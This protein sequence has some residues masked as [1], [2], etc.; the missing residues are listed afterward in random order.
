MKTLRQE[1]VAK[2]LCEMEEHKIEDT[3][4]NRISLLVGVQM[5]WDEEKF[6]FNRMPYRLALNDEIFSL[7]VKKIVASV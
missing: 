5:A 6:S 4:E 3:L 2:M 1:I 7:K